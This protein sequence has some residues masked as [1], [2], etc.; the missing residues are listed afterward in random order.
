MPD[1]V[2]H[3][4]ITDLA[5]ALGTHDLMEWIE[6]ECSRLAVAGLSNG[7]VRLNRSLLDQVRIRDIAVTMETDGLAKLLPD[8]HD[9]FKVR[10][11]PF[12]SSRERR[13]WI[14]HEIAHTLWYR[15]DSN[16]V[17]LSSLQSFVGPDSTIEWLCNRAAAALLIP[18]TLLDDSNQLALHGLRDGDLHLLERC[19]VALDVP[20]RL[21]ARRIWHDLLRQDKVIMAIA[22]PRDLEDGSSSFIPLAFGR[23]PALHEEPTLDP[24]RRHAPSKTVRWAAVPERLGRAYRRR[25]ERRAVS[26]ALL[27]QVPQ[28]QTCVVQLP[29]QW[30]SFLAPSL[31]KGRAVP[32]ARGGEG[33]DL[34]ARAGQ[35]GRTLF[36]EVNMADMA[37]SGIA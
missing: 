12:S 10:V 31:A 5:R 20:E 22:S 30:R 7:C 17:P 24:E 1:R 36:L 21:L 3:A 33:R 11:R 15:R 19:A 34:V 9:G 8:G 25:L 14:A 26:A 13:F 2:D 4:L 35:L 37:A 6:D 16:H 32:L 18:R 27:P 28:G 29:G 23:D